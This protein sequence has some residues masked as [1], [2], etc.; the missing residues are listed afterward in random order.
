MMNLFDG[1]KWVYW[2]HIFVGVPL[3]TC[4][5]LFYVITGDM[6]HTDVV[7]PWFYI[8]LAVGAAMLV[9]HL[10]KLLR[11]FDLIKG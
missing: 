11:S 7:T 3:L 10:L 8:L 6:P 9:Y 1:H 2:F 4:I 5:P